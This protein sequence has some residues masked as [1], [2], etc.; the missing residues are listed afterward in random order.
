VWGVQME[1]LVNNHKLTIPWNR[2]RTVL[3]IVR[4]G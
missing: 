2:K 4:L 1:E 3:G